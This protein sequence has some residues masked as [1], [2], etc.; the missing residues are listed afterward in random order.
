MDCNMPIMDGF[1]ATEILKGRMKMKLL[2]W[3]PIVAVTACKTVTTEEK[4]KKVGMDD[5]LSK[6]CLK[7][8]FD[9]MLNKWIITT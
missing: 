7:S 9:A 5:F 4:C 6:P 2:P 8:H 3:S 1:T